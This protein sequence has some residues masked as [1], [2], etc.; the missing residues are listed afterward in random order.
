V[1]ASN[2]SWLPPHQSLL[3]KPLAPSISHFSL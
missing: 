3:K 2:G 1:A